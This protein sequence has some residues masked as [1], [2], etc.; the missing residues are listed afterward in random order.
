MKILPYES[1]LKD[2][3][4]YLINKEL[5]RLENKFKDGMGQM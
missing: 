5:P 1:Y 4:Q 2:H 3:K